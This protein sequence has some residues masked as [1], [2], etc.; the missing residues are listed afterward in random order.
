MDESGAA[1]KGRLSSRAVKGAGVSSAKAPKKK[2]LEEIFVPGEHRPSFEYC[3]VTHSNLGGEGPDSGAPTLR[4][5]NVSVISGMSVDMVVSVNDAFYHAGNNARNGFNAPF[6]SIN[7]KCGVDTYITF[8]FYEHDTMTP[9]RAEKMYLAFFDVD[10]GSAEGLI[11]QV[12]FDNGLVDYYVTSTTE[13]KLIPS[14]NG[15]FWESTTP[16]TGADNPTSVTDITQQQ[17]DRAV[18]ALFVNQT[19]ITA[20]I[21]VAKPDDSVTCP[22]EG[23]NFLFA[24]R[25]SVLVTASQEHKAVKW[26]TTTT[27][28]KCLQLHFGEKSV[29]RS[30][31]GG[32]GPDVELT[33][34]VVFS[35]VSTYKGKKIDLAVSV[36]SGDYAPGN[37]S[38]NGVFKGWASINGACGSEARMRFELYDSFDGSPVHVPRLCVSFA[39]LDTGINSAC[40]ESITIGGF[41]G[42]HLS[43]DTELSMESADGGEKTI[44]AGTPGNGSDNP[45]KGSHAARSL[46][47]TVEFEFDDASEFEAT[48]AWAPLPGWRDVTGRNIL[49]GGP[50]YLQEENELA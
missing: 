10:S 4:Y 9:V 16:G 12:G 37:A 41:T 32:K 2:T 24:F 48:L 45:S 19:S 46:R 23:R 17:K 22:P 42:F 40:A 27:T 29:I 25:P 30:N 43:K 13:L 6:G 15:P 35:K 49:I 26:T 8:S 21:G 1:Q 36:I 11:E 28:P 18:A 5:A 20:H 14:K 7:A 33:N 44:I 34:G 3:S 47:R 38:R 50:K 39:D 31:L